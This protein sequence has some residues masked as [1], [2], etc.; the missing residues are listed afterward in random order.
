M[1]GAE[2]AL[3]RCCS[4]YYWY[5][6][7]AIFYLIQR[8][9]FSPDSTFLKSELV[10]SRM[11]HF[12]P[13]HCKQKKSPKIQVTLTKKGGIIIIPWPCFLDLPWSPCC[14]PEP[15]ALP[16]RLPEPP[17]EQQKWKPAFPFHLVLTL[18]NRCPP[19]PN[20]PAPQISRTE[21]NS[22]LGWSH[23]TRGKAFALES[24]PGWNPISDTFYLCDLEQVALL[25]WAQVS[26]SV[27][28]AVG[29]SHLGTISLAVWDHG[30]LNSSWQAFRNKDNFLSLF[31]IRRWR[32]QR[33]E[34]QGLVTH[35]Y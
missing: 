3:N 19:K 26:L 13:P 28:W 31:Q 4:C 22:C 14:Y 9:T 16:A 6:S 35:G 27:K 8:W 20:K 11:G 15:P 10:A 33:G 7:A 32:S 17:R 2:W 30:L 23:D 25:L 24:G 12:P 21:F 5:C 18:H 34:G 1:P 29:K